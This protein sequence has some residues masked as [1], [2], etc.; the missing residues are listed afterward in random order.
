MGRKNLYGYIINSIMVIV[1]GII[2][3]KQMDYTTNRFLNWVSLVLIVIIIG[4]LTIVFL[5]LKTQI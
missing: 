2:Y 5:V 1:L 3:W 4:M